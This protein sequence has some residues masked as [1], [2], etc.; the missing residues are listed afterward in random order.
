MNND[1]PFTDEEI[2]RLDPA[3]APRRCD[4]RHEV[5]DRWKGIERPTGFERD[6]MAENDRLRA[7]LA[8]T[9]QD[10]ADNLADY[11]DL[12]DGV[13]RFEGAGMTQ[14]EARL[15]AVIALCDEYPGP[16]WVH[17]ERVHRIRAAA[18]GDRK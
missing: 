11:T 15:A 2:P 7:E 3:S 14:A 17:A 13:G 4:R 10:A 18:I 12:R 6:L 9:Q 16:Q 1:S 8:Q 5:N